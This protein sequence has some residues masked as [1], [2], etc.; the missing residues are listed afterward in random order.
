[1]PKLDPTDWFL[2]AVAGFVALTSL[3][4]LM[5]NHHETLL[6][7]LRSQLAMRQRK[8]QKKPTAEPPRKAA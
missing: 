5:R 4:R 1:M 8:G 6:G 2:L 3:V 7:Q